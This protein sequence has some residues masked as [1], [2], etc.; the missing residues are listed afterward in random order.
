MQH[1]LH[2]LVHQ[3]FDKLHVG[4]Q[5]GEQLSAGRIHVIF[6]GQGL[7]LLNNTHLEAGLR[8]PDKALVEY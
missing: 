7:Q 4:D 3:H 2:L 5:L 8:L 6:H 1:I